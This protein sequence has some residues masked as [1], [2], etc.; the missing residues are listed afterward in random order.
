MFKIYERLSNT[1]QPIFELSKLPY[2]A[3]KSATVPNQNREPQVKN[4]KTSLGK[5]KYPYGALLSK[6]QKQ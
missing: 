4:I 2:R 1:T 3:S 6:N 5:E